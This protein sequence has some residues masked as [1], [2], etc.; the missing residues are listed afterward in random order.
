MF[1]DSPDN[2]LPKELRISKKELLLLLKNKVLMYPDILMRNI[3]RGNFAQF[4]NLA[5]KYNLPLYFTADPILSGLNLVL[6]E[7]QIIIGEKYIFPL[8]GI[9][10]SKILNELDKAL[11]EA[12][13]HKFSIIE[14]KRY[15]YVLLEILAFDIN[16]E[17][18]PKYDLPR[19]NIYHIVLAIVSQDFK[20]KFEMFGKP[21]TLDF[22]KFKATR[23]MA[24]SKYLTN[25]NR[26]LK[27]LSSLKL[28]V[29]DD[30]QILWILAKAINDSNTGGYYKAL[31]TYIKYFQEGWEMHQN[32]LKLYEIGKV[33]GIN[34]YVLS[35]MQQKKLLSKFIRLKD[36][37]IAFQNLD[38]ANNQNFKDDEVPYTY[39][40][41]RYNSI[42]DW[43]H[44]ITK[45]EKKGRVI[46]TISEFLHSVLQND[47]EFSLI[48][49]RQ[50]V[51]PKKIDNK[52]FY[53]YRDGINIL[54]RIAKSYELVKKDLNNK[55]FSE[56]FRKNLVA[57]YVYILNKLTS[58]PKNVNL[59]ENAIEG[60]TKLGSFGEFCHT[61][62]YLTKKKLEVPSIGKVKEIYVHPSLE[63]FEE[64]KELIRIIK[65]KVNKIHDLYP[66][67][68]H[69]FDQYMDKNLERVNSAIDIMINY[70]KQQ[71]DN[72]IDEKD[73]IFDIITKGGKNY[74][75]W[76]SQFVQP[77]NYKDTDIH[78]FMQHNF[79]GYIY[80]TNLPDYEEYEGSLSSMMNNF[81][82]VGLRLVHDKNSNSY[83]ILIFS[84]FN[85]IEFIAPLGQQ[86]EESFKQMDK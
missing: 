16:V 15:F 6:R 19:M 11:K 9:M 62:P 65:K 22:S 28:S 50:T 8:L 71:I 77:H 83:K 34:E 53:Q 5:I 7:T 41:P 35:E 73:P 27:W 84:T 26:G 38:F 56:K 57:H 12:P 51:D 18:P 43:F 31:S 4:F 81:N 46:L 44:S 3:Y 24:D 75:G 48:N 33:F 69:P 67:N 54:D 74:D 61:V 25:T 70:K 85:P 86:W 59:I 60:L 23:G 45:V 79:A 32:L 63:F 13:D 40:L 68:P 17:D 66:G 21:R 36:Y 42:V 20:Y 2:K 52:T 80:K 82:K 14:L 10:G 37:P 29:I 72:V 55:D 47:A 49:M 30:I 1:L 64:I 58:D 39:I 76:Y 78:S